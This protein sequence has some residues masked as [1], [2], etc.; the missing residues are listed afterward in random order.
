MITPESLIHLFESVATVSHDHLQKYLQHPE[1]YTTSSVLVHLDIL[2]RCRNLA[3]IAAAMEMLQH[4]PPPPSR[5]S[6]N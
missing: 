3:G 5:E 2:L 6:M 1:E 4:E